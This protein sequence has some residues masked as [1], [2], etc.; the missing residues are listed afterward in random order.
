MRRQLF[1]LLLKNNENLYFTDETGWNYTQ[2]INEVTFDSIKQFYT[3]KAFRDGEYV[4]TEDLEEFIMH[5]SPKSVLDFIEFF[6]QQCSNETFQEKINVLF[7]LNDVN[8]TIIN[9][10]FSISGSNIGKA[11]KDLIKERGIQELLSDAHQFYL[12]GNFSVATEKLWDAFERLKTFY[13][14]TLDKKQSVEKIIIQ[15]SSGEQNIQT[16][17]ED[18]FKKLTKLGNMFRIRHHEIG[19]IDIID[20]RHFEY[21][22]NRCS[23]LMAT[24]IKV[25]YN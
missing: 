7:K 11:P 8:T 13:S 18:E 6:S 22:Y 3:P 12:E 4:E 21:L 14:P 16:V 15:M 10:E 23:T 17:F 1:Q 9:N 2:T 20:D 5:T 25:L 19:K 24:A